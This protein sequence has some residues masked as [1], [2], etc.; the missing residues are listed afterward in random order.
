MEGGAIVGG[1]LFVH[2]G[3]EFPEYNGHLTA[4]NGRTQERSHHTQSLDRR[5]LWLAGKPECLSWRP[6][7]LNLTTTGLCSEQLCNLSHAPPP[8]R[9]SAR[10]ARK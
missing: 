5:R 3:R 4:L 2:G 7:P 9:L 8:V 1:Y 6:S 10:L